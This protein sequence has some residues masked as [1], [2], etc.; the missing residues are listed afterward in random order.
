MRDLT[1]YR[2]SMS[3]SQL[4][5][6]FDYRTNSAVNRHRGSV[7]RIHFPSVPA[8]PNQGSYGLESCLADLKR[9]V[10]DEAANHQRRTA[11]VAE[12]LNLPVVTRAYSLDELAANIREAISPH[13]GFRLRMLHGARNKLPLVRNRVFGPSS[14]WD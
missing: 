5:P 9:A 14:R 3:I 8:Q 2:P 11:F 1:K 4:H 13:L 6:A 12:C 7:P 10:Q